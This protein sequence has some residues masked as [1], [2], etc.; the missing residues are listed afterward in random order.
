VYIKLE[1]GTEPT[2]EI[3]SPTLYKTVDIMLDDNTLRREERTKHA[4][5]TAKGRIDEEENKRTPSLFLNR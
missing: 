2:E 3:N 4:D 1:R 5:L